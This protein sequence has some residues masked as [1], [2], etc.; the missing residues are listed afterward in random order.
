[1]IGGEEE[2]GE[3]EGRG[4]KVEEEGREG[5]LLDGPPLPEVSHL[6]VRGTDL[7]WGSYAR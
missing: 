6:L 7:S 2:E 5:G 3:E 4:G 1:M